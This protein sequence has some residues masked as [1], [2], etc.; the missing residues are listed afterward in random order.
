MI[1]IPGNHG[2]DTGIWTS[3]LNHCGESDVLCELGYEAHIGPNSI[4][5]HSAVQ[6]MVACEVNLIHTC[7]WAY[8]SKKF[9]VDYHFITDFVLIA[10]ISGEFLKVRDAVFLICHCTNVILDL[11]VMVSRIVVVPLCWVIHSN[12]VAVTFCAKCCKIA[13][14]EM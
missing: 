1:F 4:I 8:A 7:G 6:P 10:I 3:A 14:D 13:T 5:L 12:I 11:N 2:V 9:Q